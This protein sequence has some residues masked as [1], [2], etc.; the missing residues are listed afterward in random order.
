VLGEGLTLD[1]ADALAGQASRLHR[2]N[3]L[4]LGRLAPARYAVRAATPLRKVVLTMWPDGYM[5]PR[6]ESPGEPVY[7]PDYPGI[8][9]E[10]PGGR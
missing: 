3:H 4:H 7:H 9:F 6:R 8:E 10:L 2:G 5:V 1:L